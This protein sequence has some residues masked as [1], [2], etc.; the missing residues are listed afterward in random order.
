M[1]TRIFLLIAVLG[2]LSA[3]ALEVSDV[4][5]HQ[6]WPW[7]NL[8]DVDFV[9]H[10]NGTESSTSFRIT[11]AGTYNNGAQ[12]VTGSTFA[13]APNAVAGTNRVTWNLG[14][15]YPGLRTDD[16]TLTVAATEQPTTYLKIDISGGSEATSFPVTYTTQP[17]DLGGDLCRTTELWLRCIP[18][19]ASFMMGSPGGELGR[20]LDEGSKLVSLTKAYY[21][22]VFEVTQKQWWQITGEL[23]AYYTNELYRA[24]RPME[25]I[26]YNH[27]RG[28]FSGANWPASS[29]VDDTSLIGIL[30]DKTG[31]NTLDLPT[32]A[33]WE[34]ACRAGATTALY[35]G[36]NLLSTVTDPNVAL[37]ARY[38]YSTAVANETYM[39][40][41]VGTT[42]GTAA[43][44]SY[45][46]NAWGLYDMNG[47]V[48]EWCLDWYGDTLQGGADPKGPAT[49]SMRS[50]RGGSYDSPA[51]Y[52][53]SAWRWK[54]HPSNS[55][56]TFGCRIAVTVP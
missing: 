30:R 21:I 20:A 24:T 28:S 52:Q 34:Y 22:G 25:N 39:E 11:L 35:N 13:N 8:V 5:A 43:V 53:R 46:P 48:I 4:T 3:E 31:I 45:L 51:S 26:S 55:G 29:A 7:N 6:R 12:T 42:N 23:P 16:L 37:L 14:A 32:E 2:L 27:L 49:G 38:K 17:P 15:D 44:G 41:D 9:I 36:T 33:Q 50:R 40:R 18:A 19:G 54:Q 1:K 56:P 47:N 10:T